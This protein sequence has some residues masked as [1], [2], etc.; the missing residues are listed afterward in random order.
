MSNLPSPTDIE[1]LRASD[2]RLYSSLRRLD[3]ATLGAA[4]HLPGWTRGHV[5][6]HLARNADALVNVLR[7]RPMYPVPASR[8]SEIARDA[9]RPRDAHLADLRAASDR[10]HAAFAA[11]SADGWERT[12]VLRNG[13]TDRVGSLPFRRRA[14]VELHHVDLGVGYTLDDLPA[15]FTERELAVVAGRFERDPAVPTSI[16]LRVDGGGVLHTGG[17]G[18]PSLVVSGTATALLGWLTGRTDGSGLTGNTPLPEL[19]GL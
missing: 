17:P 3:D 6:A 19:P 7:G 9:D 11:E 8:E 18:E 2:Q 1:L 10:L 5:L 4:S 14:E 13:V 16:E 12:V 15:E